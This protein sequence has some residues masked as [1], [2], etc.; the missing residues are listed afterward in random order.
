MLQYYLTHFQ[1]MSSGKVKD[2]VPRWKTLKNLEADFSQDPLASITAEKQKSRI[3][4]KSLS[5][6][7]LGD[8]NQPNLALHRSVFP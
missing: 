1:K 7:T 8:L 3:L 4:T 5:Y 6:T 2:Q